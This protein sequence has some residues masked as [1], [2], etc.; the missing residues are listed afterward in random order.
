MSAD[1][2]MVE[3][4]F[5]EFGVF[6]MARAGWAASNS[7]DKV[8][9]VSETEAQLR[10][11]LDASGIG[12]LVVQAETY[13]QMHEDAVELGYSS[14]LEALEDLERMKNDAALSRARATVEKGGAPDCPFCSG[15]STFSGDPARSF[16]DEH[17][18]QYLLTFQ[19]VAKDL[20]AYRARATQEKSS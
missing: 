17:Y 19:I 14:I 20:A 16:C 6:H 18:R 4:L 1:S 9:E 13:R 8:R 15:R 5:G 3:R 2:D 11:A 12:E 7:H 10:A